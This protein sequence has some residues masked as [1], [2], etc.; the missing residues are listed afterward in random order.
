MQQRYTAYEAQVWARRQR[1]GGDVAAKI[2]LMI[3]S[4]YA[5]EWGTC[6][7][8]VDR[9]AEESEL[10]RSTVLRRLKALA[11]A[12]LVTIER[13]ANDRGHRTSNR[14]VLEIALTITSQQWL[15]A[16]EKVKAKLAV[17]PEEE[18]QGVNVTL[19]SPEP[20]KCQPE[21]GSKVS[22]GDTGTTSGTTSSTPYPLG[23]A[24][25]EHQQ[26]A[27]G[28]LGIVGGSAPS[29]APT[30]PQIAF[31]EF[32][33]IYPRRTSKL[34]AERAFL[35]A[36]S[37]VDPKVIIAAVPAAVAQWKHEERPI[38]KVPYPATW[39]NNSGW[40]DE[41][42]AHAA[43]AASPWTTAPSASDVYRESVGE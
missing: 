32:W 13:R 43:P 41:H 42:P 24:A 14:Y 30:P 39:L 8:G 17:E 33:A 22:P 31:S 7:P 21:R 27:Q 4:D 20:P 10:S 23:A 36:A 19:G 37:R 2:I 40:E 29:A 3:L 1:L 35:K 6:Y 38:D 26:G 5:D 9:I 15:A 18:V 34:A 12:G 25:D 16:V 28:V 11:Q